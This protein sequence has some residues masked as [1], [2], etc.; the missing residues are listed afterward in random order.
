M[1]LRRAAFLYREGMADLLS[2][3]DTVED[4]DELSASDL[5]G[6]FMSTVN[7]KWYKYYEDPSSFANLMRKTEDS[8]YKAVNE[9]YQSYLKSEEDVRLGVMLNALNKCKTFD[10]QCALYRNWANTEWS[11]DEDMWII[12]VGTRLMDEDHYTPFLHDVWRIWRTLC[13]GMF[14][15]LSHDSEIPNKFYND[16]RARCYAACLKHINTHTNDV[17]A[18]NCASVL[19]GKTNINR[20]GPFDFGNQSMLEAVELLPNRYKSLYNTTEDSADSVD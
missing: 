5:K 11:S 8:L 16:Y 17:L 19:A 7:N 12:A 14:C 10:D 20:Y 18:I 1:E 9:A 15:G 13:Q 4:E 6:A 2:N 3:A